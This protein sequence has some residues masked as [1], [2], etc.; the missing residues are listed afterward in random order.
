MPT[1]DLGSVLGVRTVSVMEVR[2][3]GSMVTSW[4][5][6]WA[7]WGGRRESQKVK[8]CS[9]DCWAYFWRSV[10]TCSAVG[11]GAVGQTP[12]ERAEYVASRGWR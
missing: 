8:T 5:Y 1:G 12:R 9:C 11:E 7:F 10:A 2:R 4:A 6:N 3:A